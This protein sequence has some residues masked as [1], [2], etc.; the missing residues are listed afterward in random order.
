[1]FNWFKKVF[2]NSA[3][4]IVAAA[5]AVAKAKLYGSLDHTDKLD[6][7]HKAI[8]RGL[9]DEFIDDLLKEVRK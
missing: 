9:I 7:V 3:P 2:T 6:V 1:M 8:V 4:V 5:V